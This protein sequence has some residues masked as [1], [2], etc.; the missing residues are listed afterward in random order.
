[1][2]ASYEVDGNELAGATVLPDSSQPFSPV[3][4]GRWLMERRRS[5]LQATPGRLD[6]QQYLISSMR[7]T[8]RDLGRMGVV[9]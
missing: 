6:Y 8:M 1:M 4:V 7:P 2:H 5:R 9:L 3:G